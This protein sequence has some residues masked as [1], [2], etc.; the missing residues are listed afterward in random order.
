M[1]RRK[2]L[3]G[4]M[5][6]AVFLVFGMVSF[7]KTLTPYVSFAEA[8][9]A[10]RTVQVKGY[11]DH[12]NARFDPERKAFTFSMKDEEGELMNVVYRGPKPG[13][14]EQAE[15]VVAI[16]RFHED[17]LQSD[18]ILVKCPSK[19]ESDYPGTTGAPGGGPGR[20]A[21]R[22]DGTPEAPARPPEEAGPG[23]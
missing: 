23:S 7:Q 13:N 11:P 2:L 21:V 8:R 18:Q 15:S 17:A 22:L 3:I 19:Y 16:G 1:N 5:V 6:I 10:G 20:P 9:A 12:R 14:F 4:G